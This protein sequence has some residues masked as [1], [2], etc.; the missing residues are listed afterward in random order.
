MNNKKGFTLV[1]LLAVIAILAILVVLAIPNI[2][3]LV[4]KT[5]KN[6]AETSAKSLVST[7]KNYYIK[8]EMHGNTINEIDLTD[9]D[10]EYTEERVTKGKLTINK[11][12]SS[13]GKIYI[14]GYCV[15]VKSSGDVTS[16]KVDE[17]DCSLTPEVIT[18]TL[19]NKKFEVEE[20]TTLETFLKGLD[21]QQVIKDTITQ[22][23][24]EDYDG[25]IIIADNNA[26]KIMDLKNR[27]ISSD[28]TFTTIICYS[29]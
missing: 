20:G 8:Q 23:Y 24:F 18:F 7:A 25:A 12:G 16:E 3:S 11:D 19:N 29:N 5:R 1:E 10:F 6:L 15:K 17:N 28:D 26:N 21:D 2:I 4:E 9:P 14:R 27:K 22:Y 13:Y